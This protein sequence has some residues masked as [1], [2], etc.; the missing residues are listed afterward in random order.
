MLRAEHLVHLRCEVIDEKTPGL[1]REVMDHP[2]VR[3][4]SVMEHLP[5]IRQTRDLDGYIRRVSDIRRESPEIT[6]ERV[7]EMIA[8]KSEIGRKVRPEV[9]ALAKARGL[10]L[11]SHDDTDIAH[12]DLAADEGV[13]ISEFPCTLEA[14]REARIRGMATVGGAPNILRGQSQSGNVAMRDLMAENLL[15][16]LAS[17]YVPR[18]MLDAAFL[19]ADSGDFTEELPAAIRMV[20]KAPA[21]AAGLPDRGEIT[22]GRRADLVWIGLFEGHPF[23]RMIWRE[24][25]RVA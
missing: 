3:I 23:P 8:E 17:D 24:G 20:S 2:L 6:R 14:A 9:V 18:S 22:P 15:D 25:M 11:L 16:I 12:V 4:A 21:E 19:I 1:M 5:G 7:M 13:A 10:P